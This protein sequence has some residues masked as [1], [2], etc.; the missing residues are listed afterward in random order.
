[1]S[2]VIGNWKMHGLREEAVALSDALKGS[3][4]SVDTTRAMVGVCPPATVVYDVV[5]RLEGSA[6]AVGGQDCHYEVSGAFTGDVSA[7]MLKDAGCSLVLVGHSERRMYHYESNQLVQQKASAAVAQGLVPVV[8]VGETLEQ[9]DN[10]EADRVIAE[11]LA[12]SIPDDVVA[13]QLL[14][15]YEPV[16][17]IGTGRTATVEQIS[18]MHQ[19]IKNTIKSQRGF[20]QSCKILYGGSVK[21]TNIAE[22]IAVDAVDGVLVGGASLDVDAFAAIVSAV[23]ATA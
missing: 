5:E 8:C 14:V 15:A 12:G 23:V 20:A 22:I 7:A 21:P 4:I 3:L 1:M 11:Q 9:R 6:I 18:S 2:V 13:D 10:G 16:W 19:H 17:A